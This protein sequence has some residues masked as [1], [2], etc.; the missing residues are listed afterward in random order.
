[1]LIREGSAQS[2]PGHS[3]RLPICD[4]TLGGIR[5]PDDQPAPFHKLRPGCHVGILPELDAESA[6]EAVEAIRSLISDPSVSGDR[7]IYSLA[8]H[9]IFEEDPNAPGEFIA[10]V[11]CSCASLV[12]WCYEQ[13]GKDADLISEAVVPEQTA[14]QLWQKL[15]RGAPF[16]AEEAA[17][18]LVGWGLSGPGPWRVLLPAYQMRAFQQAR[19]ILPYA[20][21]LED[22]PYAAA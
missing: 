18:R 22:H 2:G 17:E 12:E 19:G 21:T 3:V 7:G 4:M 1:M 9:G 5:Y 15:M 11:R 6:Q 10:G 14:E 16:N 13:I 8:T 20:P